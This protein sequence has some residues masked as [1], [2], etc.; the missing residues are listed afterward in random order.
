MSAIERNVEHDKG[1]VAVLNRVGRRGPV[2]K[3]TS[4]PRFAGSEGAG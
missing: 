2:E 3:G 1:A 4:E